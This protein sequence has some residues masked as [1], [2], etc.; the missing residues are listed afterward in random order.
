[1]VAEY[2]QSKQLQDVKDTVAELADVHRVPKAVVTGT[3]VLYAYQRKPE[4]FKCIAEMLV[5]LAKDGTIYDKE[6]QEAYDL[7][8]YII[9]LLVI[10]GNFYDVLIDCPTA[11][12]RLNEL[13][14][15]WEKNGILTQ[16]LKEKCEKHV[17][18]VK[19]KL[20]EDYKKKSE[21]VTA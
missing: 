17:V 13:L 15:E 20:E 5:K 12:E 11:V 14:V 7:V 16:E 9:R 4:E 1:M 19:K 6:L 8:D 21:K 18:E 3:F 2:L 10:M